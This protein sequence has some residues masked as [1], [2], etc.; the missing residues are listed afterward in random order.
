MIHFAKRIIQVVQGEFR[1]SSCADEELSTILGSCVAAC[2]WDDEARVGGMNHFVLPFG[3]EAAGRGSA[4][5]GAQSM[6]M[7]INGLLRQNANRGNL[8]AKLFGGATMSANLGRIGLDNAA[9]ARAFLASARI[10]CLAEDLGGGF[11]RRVL[12]QPTTGRARVMQVRG[13]D[14]AA[15][16]EVSAPASAWSNGDVELF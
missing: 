7:L 15:A 14:I 6:E 4:R 12:F 9:F 2:I 5:Y 3:G 16:I 10:P 13:I 1:V 11:A 8:R